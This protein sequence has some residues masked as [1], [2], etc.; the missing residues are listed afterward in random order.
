[1]EVFKRTQADIEI[2]GIKHTVTITIETDFCDSD[3]LDM[4]FESEE[5]KANFIRKLDNG[6]YS[7]LYIRVRASLPGFVDQ[8][9]DAL[10][11]CIVSNPTD[12]DNIIEEHGMIDNAV[13][14][15][16]KSL[17]SQYQFLNNLFN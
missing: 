16:D 1:M 8:G 11:G 2:N 13:S 14:D 10:G 12:I 9:Q 5:D 15:L 4:D 6:T 17:K 3:P 7:N